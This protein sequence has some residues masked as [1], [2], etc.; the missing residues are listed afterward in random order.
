MFFIY[1]NE[2]TLPL[3]ELDFFM[4]GQI[5]STA[6]FTLVETSVRRRLKKYFFLANFIIDY[7]YF[8][9]VFFNLNFM[10]AAE[11]S[12]LHLTPINQ[13]LLVCIFVVAYCIFLRFYCQLNHF[14]ISLLRVI[15]SRFP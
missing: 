7:L 10:V 2:I 14:C 4:Q 3:H 9:E 13:C 1:D 11:S 8:L 15:Y 6:A 12:S 5:A